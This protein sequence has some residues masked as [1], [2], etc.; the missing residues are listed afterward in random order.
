[1]PSACEACSTAWQHSVELCSGSAQAAELVV[2]AFPT[3]PPPPH[4][5]PPGPAY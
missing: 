4:P 2:H 5:P 1:L 3:T